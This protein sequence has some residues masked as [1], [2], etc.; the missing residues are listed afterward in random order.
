MASR[1]HILKISCDLFLHRGCKSVTM[2]DIASEV[3][4]SKRTRYEQF[5]DKT[6]LLHECIMLMGRRD[7]EKIRELHSKSANVLEFLFSIHK[8]RAESR[9]SIY[10]NFFQEVRKFYPDVY[11][12]IIS[13]LRRSH[14]SG[15]REMILQGKEQG[16]FLPRL[17]VDMAATVISEIINVINNTKLGVDVN[18]NRKDFVKNAMFIFLRGMST[19]VGVEIIDRFLDSNVNNN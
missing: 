1:E 8:Y 6:Q 12:G 18:F 19:K 17:D 11:E 13:R 3:G 2:D 15:T 4:I 7:E 5:K 10:E 14:F 9:M 16:L